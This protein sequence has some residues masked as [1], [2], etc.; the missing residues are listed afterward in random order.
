MLQASPPHH[1]F[2]K[3]D[4]QYTETHLVVTKDVTN[5]V[6]WVQNGYIMGCLVFQADDDI[7]TKPC[8][9]LI[10]QTFKNTEGRVPL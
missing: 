9:M 1:P 6:Q 4:R 5:L 7:F 8:D 2:H 3:E 10:N